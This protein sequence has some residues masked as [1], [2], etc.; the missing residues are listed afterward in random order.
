MVSSP[1]VSSADMLTNISVF[2]FPPKLSLINMVKGWF[3]YGM[4]FALVVSAAITSPRAV[5][6]LLI[7]VPSSREVPDVPDF[8]I[9]SDPA[10]S[11]SV[12][13]PTVV[14][15]VFVFMQSI[16]N[17]IKRWLRLLSEF[18]NVAAVCLC[19]WPVRINTST[20]SGECTSLHVKF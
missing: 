5:N 18:I 11:T 16:L 17:V 2:A 14:I 7:A 1:F 6:D 10:K 9:R 19:L 3:L 20:S 13:L 8:P 12:S 15:L 4:C